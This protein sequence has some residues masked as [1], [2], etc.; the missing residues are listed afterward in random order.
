MDN[1]MEKNMEHEMETVLYGCYT[2]IFRVRLSGIR[3]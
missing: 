3:H 2:E 1:Q